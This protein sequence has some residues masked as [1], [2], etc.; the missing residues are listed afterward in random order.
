MLNTIAAQAI[1]ELSDALEAQLA[2]GAELAEAV[3]AVVKEGYAEHKRIVFN[4]DNYTEEWH[5]EAEQRGLSNLPQ[6][7]DALPALISESAVEVMSAYDVLSERELESRYE[8]FV[9]QYIAKVNIEAETTFSMAKT[10]LLPAAIRYLGELG[11]AG[12][13]AGV[14]AIRAEVAGLVDAFVEAHRRA[15]HGEHEPPGGRGRA[16]RGRVRP[17][18][19]RAG[20]E[21]RARDRRP[22]GARRAGLALAAAEVLGDPLHQV[23]PP[24]GEGEWARA[25]LTA[26]PSPCAVARRMRRMAERRQARAVSK[27][28]SRPV[29]RR[30]KLAALARRAPP[31]PTAQRSIAA[32][33]ADRAA[34]ARGPS[35]Q[36]RGCAP[37]VE[38][39]AAVAAAADRGRR[40]GVYRARA[41]TPPAWTSGR[42]RTR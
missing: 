21:R 12:E 5:A 27:P 28:R 26:G 18:H 17:A 23:A 35:R 33:V 39:V 32:E 37:L 30:T 31:R 3:L 14:A 24:G 41:G 40:A 8:V 10:M 1:D 36:K 15:R 16:R 20:D 25:P 13:S 4:G 34:A 38:Q 19:G 11:A 9:E 42:C 2:G 6:T 22:A 7:P 29:P